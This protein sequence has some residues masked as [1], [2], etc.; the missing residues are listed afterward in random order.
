MA[1]EDIDIREE[2][3]GSAVV[4][5]PNDKNAPPEAAEQREEHDDDESHEQP[6]PE[7]AQAQADEEAAAQNDDEREAIRQRRREERKQKKEH[8]KR[9]VEDLRAELDAERRQRMEMAQRL[10]AVEQ[11]NSSTD[12]AAIDNA[13]QQWEQ[14]ERVLK[15]KMAEAVTAQNG[16]AIAEL[17][18]QLYTA[19]RERERLAN[20]KQ[21]FTQRQSAPPPLDAS[22]RSLGER[23]LQKTSWYRPDSNEFD[24]QVVRWIDNEVANAGFD[25]RTQTYWDEID[26]RIAQRLPHRYRPAPAQPGNNQTQR[27]ARTPVAGGSRD[28]GAQSPGTYRLSAERVQALKDAGMWDDPKARADA[29]ARFRDYDRKNAGSR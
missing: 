12:L 10:A 23:W 18:D 17:T 20:I 28:S 1:V 24:S 4:H 25:P 5:D 22:A 3:D 6:S 21:T 8:Q 9:L 29:I 14:A 2:D 16:A 26:R 27:P 11:R 15:A 19:K 7:E 13:A